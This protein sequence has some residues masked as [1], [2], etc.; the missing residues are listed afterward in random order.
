M[1]VSIARRL[2]AVRNIV[3]MRSFLSSALVLDEGADLLGRGEEWGSLGIIR[4][5]SRG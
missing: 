2:I 5:M 3:M 4:L 1:T